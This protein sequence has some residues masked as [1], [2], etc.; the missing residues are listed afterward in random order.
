MVHIRNVRA[1]TMSGPCESLLYI[2]FT[3]Y[4]LAFGV[5]EAIIL[6]D[7]GAKS[8]CGD[9]AWYNIL[10][11]C[12]LH[13]CY[14]AISSALACD[15][16]LEERHKWRMSRIFTIAFALGIWSCVIFFDNSGECQSDHPHLWHCVEGEVVVFFGAL[17]Y[18]CCCTREAKLE[19]SV[20]EGESPV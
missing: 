13:F 5:A 1:R 15:D 16:D 11:F 4:N 7:T 6:A 17:A 8:D 3:L 12:I 10:A 19:M 9:A 14:F 2:A 18:G 20:R